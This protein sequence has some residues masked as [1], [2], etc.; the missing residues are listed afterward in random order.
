MNIKEIQ[1]ELVGQFA[2]LDDWEDKYARII[3]MG[4][5]LP[6]M[7]EEKKTDKNKLDGC[8]SQGLD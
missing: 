1:E 7:N 6:D 8:Q 2:E 3:R 5:E 4:K